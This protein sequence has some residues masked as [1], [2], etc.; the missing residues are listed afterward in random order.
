[1]DNNILLLEDIEEDDKKLTITISF[2][3]ND[4]DKALYSF[5]LRN[6]I[7]AGGKSAY[8]KQVLRKEYKKH[9]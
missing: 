5:I 6:S 2:K 8:V 3:K 9:I 1:M 7:D 4:E